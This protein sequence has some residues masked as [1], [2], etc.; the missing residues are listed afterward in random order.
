[1]VFREHVRGDGG[2]VLGIGR[3]VDRGVEDDA[4]HVIDDVTVLDEPCGV[5]DHAVHGQVVHD[6]SRSVLVAPLVSGGSD[7]V[8]MFEFHMDLSF[9]LL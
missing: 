8:A 7:A 3:D 5:A 9:L 6:A 1:M 2:D 4:V